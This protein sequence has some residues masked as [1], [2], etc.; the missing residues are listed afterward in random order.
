MAVNDWITFI[1][2]AMKKSKDGHVFSRPRSIQLDQTTARELDELNDQWAVLLNCSH[3]FGS[4]ISLVSRAVAKINDTYVHVR[5]YNDYVVVDKVKS[6]IVCVVKE[7]SQARQI[8]DL[9]AQQVR[10]RFIRDVTTAMTLE[11]SKLC[12]EGDALS[13]SVPLTVSYCVNITNR[14]FDAILADVV[15]RT[16]GESDGR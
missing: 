14:E 9:V 6:Q 16:I 3:V 2:K 8:V 13:F 11:A 10:D 12:A 4:S 7:R 5:Q 15:K 1:T